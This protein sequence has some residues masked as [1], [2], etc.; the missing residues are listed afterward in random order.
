MN[1]E[2]LM[3]K[4][5]AQAAG[6]MIHNSLAG[7]PELSWELEDALKMTLSPKSASIAALTLIYALSQDPPG[8]C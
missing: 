6:A 7:N 2:S 5:A 1:E 3:L 8:T 4:R